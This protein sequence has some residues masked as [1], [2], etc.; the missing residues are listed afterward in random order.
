MTPKSLEYIND[1]LTNA[2]INYHFARYIYGDSGPVYP[3][4]VGQY[5]ELEADSEDGMQEAVFTVSTWTRGTWSGLE[6]TKERIKALFPAVGGATAIL[7]GGNGVAVSYLRAQ[8]IP[9][10]DDYLKRVDITLNV[11]EWSE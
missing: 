10:G 9:T 8:T 3:Y 2:G 11:K 7:P 1:R 5:N 4:S 6:Q